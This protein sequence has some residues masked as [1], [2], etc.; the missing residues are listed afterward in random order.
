MISKLTNM[1]RIEYFNRV[2]KVYLEKRNYEKVVQEDRYFPFVSNMKDKRS[3]VIYEYNFG[4][5]F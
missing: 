1:Q 4:R 3:Y 2:N 5:F